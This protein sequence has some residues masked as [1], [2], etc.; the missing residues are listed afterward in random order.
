M[1]ELRL[2]KKLKVVK[3]IFLSVKN[4]KFMKI[5]IKLFS[6]NRCIINHTFMCL[7]NTWS[8]HK[9]SN[10]LMLADGHIFSAAFC[11]WPEGDGNM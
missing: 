6:A 3:I 7:L 8:K 10:F 4:V 1:W 2:E 5:D 9:I 11:L